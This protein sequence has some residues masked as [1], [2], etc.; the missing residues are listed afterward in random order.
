[1]SVTL[2]KEEAELIRQRRRE[3]Y[4][5]ENNMSVPL[6]M[7]TDVSGSEPPVQRHKL[8]YTSG[9]F[10]YL[11]INIFYILHRFKGPCRFC[12]ITCVFI[13]M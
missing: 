2:T 5:A 7:M 1:M 3:A 9:T 11:Y 10:L 4:R 8:S 6:E 13:L 12:R